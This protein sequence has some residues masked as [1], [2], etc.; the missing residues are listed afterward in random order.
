MAAAATA[1]NQERP[2]LWS[3]VT[4]LQK[5][6]KKQES[7]GSF[8]DHLSTRLLRNPRAALAASWLMTSDLSWRMVQT[9]NL[10]MGM[11]FS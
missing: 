5:R 10:E 4:E 3:W 7:L 2:R 8:P 1:L 6:G 9:L 11:P